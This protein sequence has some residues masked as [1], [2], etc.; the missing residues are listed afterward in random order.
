MK[1]GII[2]KIDLDNGDLPIN[3]IIRGPIGIINPLDNSVSLSD[4]AFVGGYWEILNG[5]EIIEED[6]VYFE[7]K[8][9]YHLLLSSNGREND[10]FSIQF[11]EDAYNSNHFQDMFIRV[12]LPLGFL[13]NYI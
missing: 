9:D 11:F 4:L 10:F 6:L 8:L 12:D 1:F 2:S 5:V 13:S 7:S 3:S